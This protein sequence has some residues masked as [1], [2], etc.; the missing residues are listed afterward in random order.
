MTLNR[1]DPFKDLLNFQEKMA[2]LMHAAAGEEAPVRKTTW[3]PVVDIVETGEA[4]IL[5]ADLPGV[6]KENINIEISGSRLTIQGE[7]PIDDEPGPAAYHHIERETGHFERSFTLPGKIDVDRARA[8]YTD[9]VLD[10]LLPKSREPRTWTT[11]VV[12][13]G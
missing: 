12:C 3:R 11:T 4:F 9:G 7:R 2:R 13:L 6:S 5:R 10:L 8:R 1:W